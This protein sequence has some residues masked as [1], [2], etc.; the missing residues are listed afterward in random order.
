MFNSIRSYVW[1]R[2]W[3]LVWTCGWWRGRTRAFGHDTK[4]SKLETHWSSRKPGFEQ[5]F[6]I[7]LAMHDGDDLHCRR[8]PVNDQILIDADGLCREHR[9]SLRRRPLVRPES[10]LRLPILLLR[11]G[12]AKSA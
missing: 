9:P 11:A 7:A 2:R 6:Y 3:G 10:C 12:N 8:S 4:Q 5:P 1:P